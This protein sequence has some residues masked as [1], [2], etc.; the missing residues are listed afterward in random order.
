MFTITDGSGLR[1]NFLR[2]EANTLEDA[3]GLA[4]G[5]TRRHHIRESVIVTN[6]VTGATFVVK[7]EE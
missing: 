5:I 3:Y 7:S 1:N 6:V 2:I 4:I